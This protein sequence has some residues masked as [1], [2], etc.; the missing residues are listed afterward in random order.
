MSSWQPEEAA[1][2][3]V[4]LNAYFFPLLFNSSSNFWECE[5]YRGKSKL[6]LS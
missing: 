3:S 1:D 4:K 6:A 2:T 5:N